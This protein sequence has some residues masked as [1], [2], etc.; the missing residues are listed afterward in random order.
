MFGKTRMYGNPTVVQGKKIHPP[1]SKAVQKVITSGTEW[2]TL[3]NF[4]LEKKLGGSLKQS[5]NFIYST[6]TRSGPGI[7]LS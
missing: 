6:A 5:Q 4:T 7:C 3:L 2:N 1:T